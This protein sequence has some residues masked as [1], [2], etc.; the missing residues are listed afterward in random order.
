[1]QRNYNEKDFSSLPLFESWG[2]RGYY[3]IDPKSSFDFSQQLLDKNIL[4]IIQEEK[5]AEFRSLIG[6]L[7]EKCLLKLNFEGEISSET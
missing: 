5:I 2:H 3:D 6:P 4:Q 7:S 1:M